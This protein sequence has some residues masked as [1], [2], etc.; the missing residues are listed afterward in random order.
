MI[1]RRSRLL[2]TAYRWSAA[3]TMG[4]AK[5]FAKPCK[6]SAVGE[7][8]QRFELF[9]IAYPWLSLR[10]NHGLKLA[11]AFGVYSYQSIPPSRNVL[12]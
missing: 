12:D 1:K 10:S 7:R 6:R 5:C 2:V 8:L 4:N 11:N 3:T 9:L